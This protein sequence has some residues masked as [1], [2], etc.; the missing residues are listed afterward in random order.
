MA[1]I[2]TIAPDTAQG[3][4]ARSYAQAIARA[5]R[6]YQIVQA[7]S[8]APQVLDASMLL[9][10]KIMHGPG[11]LSRARRELLAVVVSR[12]NACHY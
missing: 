11:P 3:D 9:Y 4:L 7:M 8:L 2:R 10:Q 12:S 5:G 6:V 1:W